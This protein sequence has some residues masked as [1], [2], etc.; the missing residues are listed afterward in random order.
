MQRALV[1]LS[2]LPVLLVAC[3]QG[4]GVVPSDSGLSSGTTPTGTG[5]GTGAST[6]TGTGTGTGAATGTGT[7]V[8]TGTG[9][10]TGSIPPSRS[11]VTGCDPTWCVLTPAGGPSGGDLCSC[12]FAG[13]DHP[14]TDS[15]EASCFGGAVVPVGYDLTL[16]LDL[17]AM[18]YAG[19]S[20]T[21]CNGYTGD[22]SVAVYDGDP[23]AGGVEVACV[24]D[25]VDEPSFCAKLTDPG[26]ELAPPW[27][28]AAPSSGVAWVV[29][30]EYD[31][32]E[33]WNGATPRQVDVELFATMPVCGDGTV[34]LAEECDDGN[35][36]TGDG[37]DAL[38]QREPVCG[39]G[40]VDAPETCDD[41]NLVEG[42]GCDALCQ[43]EPLEIRDCDPAWCTMASGAGPN[44]GDLCTCTVSGVD[45]PQVGR[46]G[47][48]CTGADGFEV[49]FSFDRAA[50]AR[51]SAST[52][53]TVAGGDSI[54]TLYGDD[55]WAGAPS[56]ACDDD[57][58]YEGYCSKVWDP[59]AAGVPAGLVGLPP[60]GARVYVAVDE[61]GEGA[62]WDGVNDR[63][64]VFEL[65][66]DSDCGNGQLDPLEDCD[67]GN[68]VDGD[69]CDASC[70]AS[71]L[72]IDGCDPA[73]CALDAGIGPHGGDLCTCTIPAAAHPQGDDSEA[74][75]CFG[76]G[77]GRELL[78]HFDASAYSAYTVDTC[79][80]A[81]T[82]AAD[83]SVATFDGDPATGTEL[84]C[85]EDATGYGSWCSRVADPGGPGAP[86]PS[87]V[88]AS[89]ELWVV[90][91]EWNLGDYWNLAD[92]R[93]FEVELIP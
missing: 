82:A 26:A 35:L 53:D 2:V 4:R 81:T 27:P 88:P 83:S 42:D 79:N 32:T 77:R 16:V 70:R 78:I 57:A 20:V 43:Q 25:A 74:G 14:I 9:T 6:G 33:I 36:A 18:G 8:A 22:G 28:T 31:R 87:A 50:Y 47:P 52:C 86:D 38:C 21:T 37:C 59:G 65:H 10:G 44:G 76:G 3:P 39:D 72:V 71:P 54:L 69:G 12:T 55:P 48:G 30:D 64:A 45:H 23:L 75:S 66:V 19:Y 80:L 91:D 84:D 92:D 68:Q 15:V 67:D 51:I 41:G 93:S 49:V 73:F 61:Y 85:S 5:T 34:E 62:W 89:G 60:G 17:T 7:G 13:A 1:L 46:F 29:F 58:A 11:L 24:E 90:I 63:V 56:S 40:F